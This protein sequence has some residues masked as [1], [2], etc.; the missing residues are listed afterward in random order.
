MR[1]R[2]LLPWNARV[3][4]EGKNPEITS[5]AYDSRKLRAGGLFVAMRGETTDGNRYIQAALERGAVA[6]VSDTPAEGVA[7]S[8]ATAVVPHGRRAL[9]EIAANFHSHPERRLALNAVTGTNGKTTTTFLLEA[10]LNSAGRKTALIGT[11]EY[12]VGNRTFPALHTTP[13]P[14]DLMVLFAEAVA[15][16]SSEVAMEVSS[17]AL[18]QGRVWGLQFDTAVFTNLTQDHLDYHG[19]MDRYFE[20]KQILFEGTGGAAPRVAIVNADDEYGRKLLYSRAVA[21]VRSFGMERGEWRAEQPCIDAQ[22][23]RFRMQTPFGNVE[24]QSR[25]MGK[26]NVYNLLAAA[27][28][29]HARGLTLEQIAAGAQKAGSVPGRFER[30]DCGQEFAVVVDY[31][32]TDDALRNLLRTAREVVGG[33]ARVICVFGCGGDRDRKKRPLMGRAAGEASDRVVVTS[34]NPRSEDA[35]EILREIEPGLAST[36]V[37]YTMEVDRRTAIETAISEAKAG[38][39]VVIAGKGHEKTQTTREGV[40]PF[41]DVAEARRAIL[42]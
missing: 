19:S 10:L 14:L 32:H 25:L 31:A 13:E 41:D 20:A 17:H 28:A 12:R 9:A 34:D 5:V 38:D 40:F 16:G 42:R 6:V 23:L 8:V 18:E 22:G 27:T 37:K 11:L 7:E 4:A 3:I 15:A 1:F 39:I 24:M 26:I 36:G 21:E 35:E 30:V 33:A 2:E 29:A